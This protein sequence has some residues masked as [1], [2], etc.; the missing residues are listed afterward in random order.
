MKDDVIYQRQQ[1]F[2]FT[3]CINCSL[4]I[5]DDNKAVI[6]RLTFNNNAEPNYTEIKISF[7]I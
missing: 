3:K 7:K 5:N 4:Q 1:A 6:I 2:E